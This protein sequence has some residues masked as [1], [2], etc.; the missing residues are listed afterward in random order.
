MKLDDFWNAITRWIFKVLNYYHFNSK[1]VK[2]SIKN[3]NNIG[4]PTHVG[5]E[6]AVD[7]ALVDYVEPNNGL[8]HT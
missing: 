8:S 4:F 5:F 2:K 7:E 1:E 3:K 6:E